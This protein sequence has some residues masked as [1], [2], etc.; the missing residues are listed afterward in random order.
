MHKIDTKNALSLPAADIC[1]ADGEVLNERSTKTST[2]C[3][4]PEREHQTSVVE[5]DCVQQTNEPARIVVYSANEIPR[6]KRGRSSKSTLLEGAMN[7]S[8]GGNSSRKMSS[9]Q[10]SEP[11][12]SLDMKTLQQENNNGEVERTPST[13]HTGKEDNNINETR[14]YCQENWVNK[15]TWQIAPISEE[16]DYKSKSQEVDEHNHCNEEFQTYSRKRSISCPSLASISA[17]KNSPKGYSSAIPVTMPRKLSESSQIKHKEI[18]QGNQDFPIVISTIIESSQ[19]I[20]LDNPE[21]MSNTQ[22]S[23]A[24]QAELSIPAPGKY[25]IYVL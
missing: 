12:P 10:S 23:F 6:R 19:S 15:R 24:S 21:A 8:N 18:S 20:I 1:K 5:D 7:N 16:E 13:S 22:L 17:S 25:I 4:Q 11:G 9:D 3:V 14:D 2:D